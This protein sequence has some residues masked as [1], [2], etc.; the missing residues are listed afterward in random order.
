M[1]LKKVLKLI[2]KTEDFNRIFAKQLTRARLNLIASACIARVFG[3]SAFCYKCGAKLPKVMA[4]MS[5]GK[6][7]VWGLQEESVK[8]DFAD[9]QTLRFCHV[10]PEQCRSN[11]KNQTTNQKS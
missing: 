6:L 1:I 5:K 2:L 11:F 8:V 10:I 9:R 3:T 7:S 4:F